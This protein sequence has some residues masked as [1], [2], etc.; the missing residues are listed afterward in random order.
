M[1]F[2]DPTANPYLAFSAML[3]AGLDGIKNK[4][5]PGDADERNLYE[6]SESELKKTPQVARSL[7]VALEELDKDRK[8]LTST[9]VFTDHQ[10]DAFINLKMLEVKELNNRPHPIEFENYFSV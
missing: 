8:F 5:L 7:N 6:L 3:L 1:R 2:P 9:G 4:I 10:L